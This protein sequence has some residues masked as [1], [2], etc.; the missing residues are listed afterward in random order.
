M[1]GGRMK[2]CIFYFT[3]TGNSLFA[4]KRL[5]EY[6]DS[7]VELISIP[8]VMKS[9]VREFDFERIGFCFPLYFTGIPEIVE[10]FIKEVTFRNVSYSFCL[11]TAGINPGFAAKQIEE[12]LKEKNIKLNTN[13][14]IYFTSNYIRK[15]K[16]AD[17]TKIKSKL[18][19][20]D[21]ELLDFAK[22]ITDCI[23]SKIKAYSIIKIMGYKQ[24]NQWKSNLHRAAESFVIDDKCNKCGTCREV[25]PTDNIKIGNNNITWGDKCQDC[26]ACIH[27]CPSGAIQIKGV[28]ENSGRY[29]NPQI[30]LDEIQHANN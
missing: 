26:I 24:Y 25:C 14:W 4:A 9:N 27:H 17:N 1:L 21:S 7:E 8:K 19:K 29:I 13:K 11:T 5:Q 2:T 10:R 28:T 15:F 3:G 6:I 30:T 18:K 12:L 16:I 23:S 22:D 20:N